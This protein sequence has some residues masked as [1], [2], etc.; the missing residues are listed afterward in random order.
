MGNRGNI[1][2][3]QDEKERLYFYTHWSGYD[4]PR[5]VAHAFDRARD[6]WNDEPYMNRVL[7]DSLL[8]G[9]H[10]DGVTGYGIDWRMGDGGTELIVNYDEKTILYNGRVFQIPE[11]VEEFYDGG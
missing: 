8:E 9:E 10:R 3:V 2:I 11:F 7:F 5:R 4:I 6:R 1:I